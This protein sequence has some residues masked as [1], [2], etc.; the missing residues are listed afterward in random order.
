MMRNTPPISLVSYFKITLVVDLDCE[1]SILP[2]SASKTTNPSRAALS[3]NQTHLYGGE[4]HMSMNFTKNQSTA[5]SSIR[6]SQ[7][8]NKPGMTPCS[9]KT[10]TR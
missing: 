9:V 4:S 5:Q 6:Q 10:P 3:M 8:L 2:A 7:Y 1:N